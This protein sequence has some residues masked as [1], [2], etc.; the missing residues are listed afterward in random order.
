MIVTKNIAQ[1]I[2]LEIWSRTVKNEM[3]MYKLH[4]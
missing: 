3:K 2:L 4:V 1:D